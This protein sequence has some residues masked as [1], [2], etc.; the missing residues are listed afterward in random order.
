MS[1]YA[2]RPG[3]HIRSL[4]DPQAVGDELARLHNIGGEGF[5]TALV[6]AA[7]RPK[8]SPLHGH[9][10]WDITGEEAQQR[11]WRPRPDT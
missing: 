5:S 11:V 3:A 8:A 6:V 4:L 2:F 1:A 10:T 7:A 9:F